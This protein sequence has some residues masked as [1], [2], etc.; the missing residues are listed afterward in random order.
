MQ[1]GLS[2]SYGKPSEWATHVKENRVGP[3]QSADRS[4]RLPKSSRNAT[5][6]DSNDKGLQTYFPSSRTSQIVDMIIFMKS[7]IVF[8]VIA[9]VH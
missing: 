6:S 1:S 3:K 5:Q 4:Q 9:I 7:Y 2:I 8:L